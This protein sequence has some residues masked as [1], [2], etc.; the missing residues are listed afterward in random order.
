M[1]RL[2]T[3]LTATY[4][5]IRNYT[6][7]WSHQGSSLNFILESISQMFVSLSRSPAKEA[8]HEGRLRKPT[9][10]PRERKKREEEKEANCRD[11]GVA[12]KPRNKEI[13]CRSGW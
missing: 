10:L 4:T 6:D 5:Y 1:F 8:K 3:F 9:T 11:L 12:N 2:V 13:P 7:A